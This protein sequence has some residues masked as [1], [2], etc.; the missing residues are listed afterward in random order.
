M[1]LKPSWLL[2]PVVLAFSTA[3]LALD[4]D[5]NQ[6]L[7]Y[8]Y[9]YG[10]VAGGSLN[11]NIG[12]NSNVT[13]I[14]VGGNYHILSDLMLTGEYEARFIHPKKTTT[15][16]YTLLPGAAYRYSILDNLDV[17]AGGIAGLLWTSQT[18]NDTDKTIEKDSYF[19]WGGNITVRYAFN[20]YLEASG[21]AEVRRSDVL[22]EE[23]YTARVDYFTSPRIAFGGYY[24]HRDKDVATSNEGGVS[25]RFFY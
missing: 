20:E 4:T 23:V 1:D 18:D 17:V 19:M 8:G 13:A 24:T 10:Q 15:R 21:V 12:E 6:K 22:D 11:E 3:T 25:V 9:F 5:A 7:D 14:A 16:I 2:T